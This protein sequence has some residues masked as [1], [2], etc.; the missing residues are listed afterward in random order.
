M[1]NIKNILLLFAL[2]ISVTA[3][4]QKGPDRGTYG[5]Q[6]NFQRTPMHTMTGSNGTATAK[7]YGVDTLTNGDTGFVYVWVGLGFAQSFELVTTVLTGTVATTSNILYGVNNGGKPLTAAQVLTATSV[8]ST[9]AYAITGNTTYCAGCVG[10]SSTTIPGAAK[11]YTWQLPDN[12][13]G[14][15][16]NYVI[17]TIQTGTATATYT[18]NVTTQK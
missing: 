12:A 2:V 3:F 18:G 8:P 17:R 6:S 7:G 10:A 14:L 15:F 1:K 11:K 5:T 13:G 16:D 9:N 4:G